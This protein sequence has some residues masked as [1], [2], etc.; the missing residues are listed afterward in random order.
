MA[1][2]KRQMNWFN[3][4]FTPTG[5]T[6][7]IFTGVLNVE[8]D[9][10]IS[11]NSFA[12]DGDRYNTTQVQD[13]GD[14]KMTVTLADIQSIESVPFGARG[15]FTAT[16]GDA[17]SQNAPG[18]GGIVYTMARAVV[19]QKNTGGQ[20]RQYGQGTLNFMSYSPDG[21]TNPLATAAA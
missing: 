9:G 13:F 14:P 18:G 16:H 10:G 6:T 20:Y 3:V 11:I 1:A 21:Y 17:V 8:I 7:I 5:G 15:T 19:G 4:S 2:S 12:G